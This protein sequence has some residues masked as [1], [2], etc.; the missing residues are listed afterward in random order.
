MKD[1]RDF[2][3]RLGVPAEISNAMGV[4]AIGCIHQIKTGKY[5]P[6][7]YGKAAA[8]TTLTVSSYPKAYDYFDRLARKLL[9]QPY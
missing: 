6:Y 2:F 5:D 8:M 1:K 9:T 7:H 3:V 4:I